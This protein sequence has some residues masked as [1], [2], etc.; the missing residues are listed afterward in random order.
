MVVAVPPFPVT[1]RLAVC[2]TGQTNRNKQTKQTN[3]KPTPV[4]DALNVR[5]LL[6]SLTRK[7]QLRILRHI[8]HS[9]LFCPYGVE[10]YIGLWM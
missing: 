5:G 9:R 10:F 8:S 2:G 1:A 4:T 6:V 7:L 3:N